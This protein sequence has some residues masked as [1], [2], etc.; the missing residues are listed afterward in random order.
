MNSIRRKVDSKL[1]EPPLRIDDLARA[2]MTTSCRDADS[3]PRV[4][5]A[6]KVVTE[7]SGR[8]VQ[9]MH[10]G[11]RIV[12]G[13][14]YG[15]WTTQIISDLRGVHEP[16]E[17]V[18][19]HSVLDRLPPNATMVEIGAYWSYYTLWFLSQS[20]STRRGIAVEPDSQN[21]R[22]GQINAT[23]NDLQ[24]EYIQAFISEN[25]IPKA[26]FRGENS[27]AL[28]VDGLSITTIFKRANIQ[29]AD[30]ILCD[31]QGGEI[32]LLQGLGDLVR[33]SRVGVVVLSTHSHH[34]T[35]DPLTHQRALNLVVALG[36]KVRIEHDVQESFSGDGLIVADFDNSLDGW[37]SPK[38]SRNRCS[39]S[40]YRN[41]LWDLASHQTTTWWKLAY[42][43][44]WIETKSRKL[45]RLRSRV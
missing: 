13:E 23:L 30:I 5:D 34:I 24:I 38:I 19:F 9:T 20:P 36:G 15:E 21:L 33:A 32:A 2:Q 35:G 44:R 22:V 18:V 40:L 12:E 26:R 10:N 3:L 37:E 42:P 8:R 17:E 29:R 4:P 41:P 39:H 11:V 1:V 6:G 31:A 27:G 14:Y 16:Q 28:R 7:P 43:L 25:D 45:L